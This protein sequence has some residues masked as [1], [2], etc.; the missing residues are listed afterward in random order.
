MKSLDAQTCL[1][2]HFRCYTIEIGIYRMKK[3]KGWR[4][5]NLMGVRTAQI[6]KNKENRDDSEL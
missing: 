1:M 2:S 4:S 3:T 6:N 5:A